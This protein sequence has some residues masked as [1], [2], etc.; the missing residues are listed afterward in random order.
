MIDTAFARYYLY[1]IGVSPQYQIYNIEPCVFGS[2]GQ[3]AGKRRA[4]GGQ[5]AAIIII[6]AC[7]NIKMIIA[8]I[9][10]WLTRLR[11]EG[12]HGTKLIRAPPLGADGSGWGAAA[13]RHNGGALAHRH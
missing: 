4:S 13:A 12:N 10:G 1:D 6:I 7:D 2:G 9:R 5:A 8:I 3:A 11:P